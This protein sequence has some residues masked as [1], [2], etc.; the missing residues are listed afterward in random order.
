[1]RYTAAEKELIRTEWPKAPTDE[2]RPLLQNRTR[3]AIDKEARRMRLEKAGTPEQAKHIAK[4]L[5]LAAL[6]LEIKNKARN[7]YYSGR[8]GCAIRVE[9]KDGAV[10]VSHQTRPEALPPI[11]TNCTVGIYRPF[12]KPEVIVRDVLEFAGA[13]A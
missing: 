5:R 10:V 1:M 9:L 11:R 13:A 7:A 8:P 3:N 6:R 2:L 4:R 12:T